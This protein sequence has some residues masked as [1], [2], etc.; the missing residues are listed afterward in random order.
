MALSFSEKRGLQKEVQT[1]LAALGE[2]P[3]F[4]AKRSLQKQLAEA[5]AKL[6][7]GIAGKRE[8]L[9]D[10]FLANKFI[11][12]AP[13]KFFSI[14]TKVYGLAQG[15]LENIKQPIIDYIKSNESL[16]IL[17]SADSNDNPIMNLDMRRDLQSTEVLQAILSKIATAGKGT[18]TINIG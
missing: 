17:E 18:I 2:T 12:E 4:K 11:R 6:V 16:M 5:L 9:V 8:S 7:A 15:Q 10:Q 13:N 3:D 1:C 14:F